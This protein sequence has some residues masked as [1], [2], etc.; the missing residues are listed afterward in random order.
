ME[1]FSDTCG[2]IPSCPNSPDYVRMHLFQ[3]SVAGDANDW[4][5]C[6]E[7][8]SMTAWAQ[9]KT[10]FLKRFNPTVRTQDWYKKIASF[11][12][13]DD[14]NLSATWSRFKR[15][16]RVCPRHEYGDNHLNT[17]FYDGHF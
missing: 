17:F 12:Q 14:D 9:L 5:K 10:T 7:P 16:I 6:L 8:N 11:T 3:L 4:Y 1:A 2:L 15:M 13:E